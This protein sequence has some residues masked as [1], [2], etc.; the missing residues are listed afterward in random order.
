M[1]SRIQII[2]RSTRLCCTRYNFNYFS[3]LISEN[4]KLTFCDKFCEI[5]NQKKINMANLNDIIFNR[6][7]RTTCSVYKADRNSL[8]SANESETCENCDK[9][10]KCR[11]KNYYIKSHKY[12]SSHFSSSKSLSRVF[13]GFF[14]LHQKN[15]RIS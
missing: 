15:S 8:R 1:V 12:R 11:Q 9:I 14:V 4:I 3:W 13:L 6:E 7:L 10:E 2:K 5:L